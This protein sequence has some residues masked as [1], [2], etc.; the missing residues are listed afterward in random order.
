MENVMVAGLHPTPQQRAAK[1]EARRQRMEEAACATGAAKKFNDVAVAIDALSRDVES[2]WRGYGPGGFFARMRLAQMGGK[3][4]QFRKAMQTSLDSESVDGGIARLAELAKALPAE[5]RQLCDKLIEATRHHVRS[6]QATHAR[7][8]TIAGFPE[9][10]QKEIKEY[11]G[12]YPSEYA[13]CVTRGDYHDTLEWRRRDFERKALKMMETQ[14][15]DVFRR[16]LSLKTAMQA[17]A[18]VRKPAEPEKPSEAGHTPTKRANRLSRLAS[19][20]TPL[21]RKER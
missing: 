7:G 6:E 8:E 5:D 3:F 17:V 11:L 18:H 16:P 15:I 13:N 19:F 12:T 2:Y 20:L 9:R 21:R 4:G 10:E 14:G 1:E